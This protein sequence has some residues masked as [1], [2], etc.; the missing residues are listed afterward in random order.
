MSQICNWSINKIFVLHIMYLYIYVRKSASQYTWR[1]EPSAHSL[2]QLIFAPSKKII[3]KFHQNNWSLLLLLFLFLL[4]NIC[5]DWKLSFQVTSHV[6]FIYGK[7]KHQN[8]SSRYCVF[9]PIS[10][11]FR[12]RIA[13]LFIMSK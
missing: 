4:Q 9:F 12:P 2:K 1:T 6:F 11:H 3:S 5:F 7:G 10:I 13:V 8:G